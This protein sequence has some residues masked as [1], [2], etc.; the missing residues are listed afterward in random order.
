M[1]L[2]G[3]RASVLAVVLRK[4]FLLVLVGTVLG[5][6]GAALVAPALSGFLAGVSPVDPLAYGGVAAVFAGVG[7]LASWLPAR[8]AARIR[9]AEALREE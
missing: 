6:G 3:S 8:R 2:G 5:L 4:G 7:L 9:P 1:A